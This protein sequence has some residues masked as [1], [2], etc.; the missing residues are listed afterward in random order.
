M[1]SEKFKRVS[2]ETREYSLR[3]EWEEG[4]DCNEKS[5]SSDA[6]EDLV[7]VFG[8]EK[9]DEGR[10]ARGEVGAEGKKDR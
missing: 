8:D 10:E 4:V 1:F 5:E 2:W 6:L 7:E 9:S 3:R